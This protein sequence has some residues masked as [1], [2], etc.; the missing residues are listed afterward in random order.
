M[1]KEKCKKAI[2]SLKNFIS[3]HMINK[4]EVIFENKSMMIF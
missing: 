1:E 3:I 4:Q 2:A